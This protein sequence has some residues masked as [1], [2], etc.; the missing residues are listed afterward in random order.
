MLVVG[1]GGA[2]KTTML[3]HL[4][5]VA[6]H[7]R[8]EEVAAA[9]V[10]FVRLNL[11]EAGGGR[12]FD[13]LLALLGEPVGL[14]GGQLHEAWLKG[15]RDLLFLLDGLNEVADDAQPA[16]EAALLRLLGE[17]RHRY[18]I[19]S[20]PTA[21]ADRLAAVVPDLVPADVVRLTPQQVREYLAGYG[22]EALYA[23]LGE[24][25][26]GLAANPFMLW[27]I[28]QACTGLESSALPSNIGAL[29]RLFVDDY[30]FG[31]R[32]PGK[33]PPPTT[34]EY[35]RAKRPVLAEVALAMTEVGQTRIAVDDALEDSARRRARASRA[36]GG[37]PSPGHARGTG[38]WTASSPRCSTTASSTRRDT[39]LAFMHE[40]VQEYFSAV[41]LRDEP[42]ADLVVRTPELHLA[43]A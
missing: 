12:T 43:A 24:E 1:D 16:V 36:R 34:F 25:L 30:V 28:V 31:R 32:E 20:R 21:T 3:L 8:A 29:Y 23:Q 42:A 6:T 39:T 37:P 27:A 9:G 38:R 17:R 10:F 14:S 22:V 33:R 40:S 7:A 5:R 19:T 4:A 13:S 35:A 11:L 26:R 18:V 2:G 41:A 15:P